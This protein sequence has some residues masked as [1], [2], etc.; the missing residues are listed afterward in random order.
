LCAKV[1]SAEQRRR[2]PGVWRFAGTEPGPIEPGLLLEGS[3]LRETRFPYREQAKST[4][5]LSYYYEKILVEEEF[6]RSKTPTAAIVLATLLPAAAGRVYNV[7]EEHTPTVAERL[8]RLPD[9]NVAASEDGQYHFAQDL[10]YDTGR[11]QQE[12]GYTE[13]VSFEDGVWRTFHAHLPCRFG[14]KPNLTPWED[15]SESSSYFS[16][17]K[18]SRI[19]SSS[20]WTWC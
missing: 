4:E 1:R 2:V 14:Q 18:E 10:A 5:E 20:A 13:A 11:I 15:F 3:P 9:S 17:R 7:G 16:E 8:A 19:R 6:M 12:F